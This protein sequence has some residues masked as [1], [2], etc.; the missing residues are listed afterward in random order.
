MQRGAVIEYHDPF[1][2]QIKL[3]D[4][5]LESSILSAELLASV[6]AVV[7]TT[8]HSSVD[9][10]FVTEH[11]SIVVDPRNAIRETKGATVYPI[12]GPPR[13]PSESLQ[14]V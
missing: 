2:P 14:P 10:E 13:M 1:V 4:H 7:V 3:E 9:Y 6:D 5:V 11:A 12:A 8:D